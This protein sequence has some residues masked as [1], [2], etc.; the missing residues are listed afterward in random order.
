MAPT[1]TPRST[2]HVRAG[3]LLRRALAGVVAVAV[4]GVC[5][6]AAYAAF[7]TSTSTA[8][9]RFAAGTVNLT[10]NDGGSAMLS[11]ASAVPGAQD[12]SCI[13]ASYSGSL[14]S[15]VRQYAAV[16]GTL[17]PY[18]SLKVTRGSGA[19]GFDNC[20]GFT[21]DSTDYLG[22]G[23]GVV[24]DGKLSDY[25][26]SYAAGIVDPDAGTYASTIL[27]TPGL[28]GYWRL[29]E[30][31]GTTAVDQKAT[32]NGTY[33]GGYTLGQ[34]G[35]LTR[36]SNTAVDFNGTSGY[37]T[38]P[39]AAALRPTS[40]IS[41]EAWVNPDSLAGTRWIVNKGTFYYL[42]ISGGLTY[43]GIRTPAGAYR[44]LTTTAVTTGSWQH[45]VGTFD[46]SRMALYRNAVNVAEGSFNDT[47][48]TSAD[49]LAIGAIGPTGSWFDGR[50][51]EVAVSNAALSAETVAA[52]YNAGLDAD[53]W[54]TPEAHDYKFEITLDNDLAVEGLSASAT[55]SWEAR[56]T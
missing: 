36:D 49:A 14:Q 34:A 13:T 42:Y 45:L 29:G 28:V 20:T 1:V 7:S 3:R 41:I 25:P 9:S 43:F 33:T 30:T 4:A 2:S 48:A 40:S 55:F 35:S 10:D 31:S 18:L 16:S 37:V 12:T 5:A 15:T 54:T 44:Y 56:N 23:N 11:L 26:T 19:A 6:A 50:I 32:S 27:A 51:D 52:H 38:V 22:D 47:I 39:D 17:A 8:G 53:V 24:Y 21:P 46:G